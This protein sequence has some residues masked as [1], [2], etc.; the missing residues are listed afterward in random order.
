M[1]DYLTRGDL[2]TIDPEV[3]ELIQ[4]EHARQFAKLI[5][6]P[7]ESSA[8]AAVR[9]AEGSV[10]QN[11]YA[12]GYAHGDMRGLTQDEILDYDTQLAHYRRY[13]DRRYYKGVEYCNLIEEL[14]KRRGA[15]A[16]CPPGLSPEQLYLNVQPLSGAIANTA[17]YEALANEGDV[18]MGMNLLHGGHLSHGSPVNHSGK[19]HHMVF[20]EVDAKTE[21]LDYDKI[22]EIAQREKPKII[23]TGYTSY[24]WAPDLQ[25]FREIADACGAYLMAD[26]SHVAGLA[27]AGVYPNPVGIAHVTTFTTHKTL[28]GPRGAVIVTTDPEL[29][30]KIDRAVFPGE[31]GGPHMNKIAAIAV[32]FK[33]ARRPEF[34]QVQHQIVANAKALAQGFMDNGLRV[35]CGGTDTHMALVD[36]KSAAPKLNGVALMGDASARILDL[37]NIVC[38]RNT[39]PG[40]RDATRPSAVR[41]G[42]PWVTQR[43]LKENDMREIADVVAQILKTAKPFSLTSARA[44]T[45]RAK[46]DFDALIDGAARISKLC[47]KAGVDIAAPRDS[48][49]HI[50]TSVASMGKN[51]AGLSALEVSGELA[52]AFLDLALTSDVN[53]LAAEETQPAWVLERNGRPMSPAIVL[54]TG[55]TYRMAVPAEKAERVARWLRALSDGYVQFDDHDAHAKLPG[56]V[57]VK[58]VSAEGFDATLLPAELNG[59]GVAEWKPYFIGR[60]TTDDGRRATN[61][62]PSTLN[63]QPST[64]LRRTALFDTHKAMGAKMVPFG[65]WEMPVW[66]TSVS[67]EHAAVR[68]AAGLF[69]VS[70]MGVL[71]ARGPNAAAFLDAVATNDV[72]DIKVGDSHYS[73]LLDPNGDVIDDIMIYR[74]EPERYLV[75]INAANNEKDIAWLTAVN[76]GRAAIDAA[77]SRAPQC[78]LR[79]LR[80]P[81]SGDDRR[82]D[83]ALQGPASLPTLMALIDDGRRTTEVDPSVVRRP[84]SVLADLPR[85]GVMR[86]TL[87]GLD[88][89]ISRTGYTGESIGY[90]IFVHPDQSVALW[91]AILKAGES[92]GVKPAGLGARD[93]TRTEAGLP[94]YGHELAGPMNLTPAHIGFGGYVKAYKPFF[95]G[96]RAYYDKA[97]Q[98]NTKLSRFRM[99]EKGVRAPKLGDPVVDSR[100]RVIGTVTSCALDSDGYLLGMAMLDTALN[101]KE[102]AAI[103]VLTLPERMPA[104]L[105]ANAPLGSRTL[106]PNAATVLTRFPKKAK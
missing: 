93:S 30:R 52:Q 71:D 96:K 85:T 58:P 63:L 39:I 13:A 68:K 106:V 82:V 51:G 1:T 20:Y 87:A 65:G 11:L 89:F 19:H 41:F 46:V 26:I 36:C 22:H 102:G 15:E 60:R 70:H 73:Y 33:L 16:V 9:E 38:N 35:V 100:G 10:L 12:E 28:L 62:Q 92:L 53:A 80:D 43:G 8:P 57:I 4:H 24:P 64:G 47:E 23:V 55:A 21:R 32:A 69:D 99:N 42:T 88:V 2:T 31:Q 94:L 45:Y 95:I 48:Y 77:G 76:E 105:A 25:K 101:A 7:S 59:T 78:E 83:I 49:P 5:M 50:W 18:L 84:S 14:C 37:A 81:S 90:E 34:K 74:V 79:D 54:N 75:V 61:P 72:Y 27:I 67:D 98:V 97:A 86:A 66:Y 56:P 40:D 91:Q 44:T 29:A 17:V 104:P 6:V 3:A 103:G